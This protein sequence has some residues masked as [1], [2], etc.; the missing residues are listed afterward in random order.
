MHLVSTC[1]SGLENHGFMDSVKIAFRY[2]MTNKW[3]QLFSII[4]TVAV[5]LPNVVALV[6]WAIVVPH[7]VVDGMPTLWCPQNARRLLICSP[8]GKLFV[9]G[10]LKSFCIINLYFIS[11]VVALIE[12]FFLSSIKPSGVCFFH[13]SNLHMSIRIKWCLLDRTDFSTAFPCPRLLA[14][15]HCSSVLRLGLSWP[16]SDGKLHIFLPG[17]GS[18]WRRKC[19]CWIDCVCVAAKHLWASCLENGATRADKVVYGVAYGIS[20]ARD[21]IIGPLEILEVWNWRN[22]FSINSH[23]SLLWMVYRGSFV[24]SDD[25]GWNGIRTFCMSIR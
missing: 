21:V 17:T 24:V 2:P 1:N 22:K 4:Y 11:L 3:R 12:V 19:C 16:R 13:I 6:Y 8:V 15:G 7:D 14:L 10:D 5:S 23:H 20:G 18:G 25:A 9:N